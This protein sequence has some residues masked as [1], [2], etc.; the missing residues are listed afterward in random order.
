MG[1]RLFSVRALGNGEHELRLANGHTAVTLSG[2]LEDAHSLLPELRETVAHVGKGTLYAVAHRRMLGAQMN[3]DGGVRTYLLFPGP[4]NWALP[5]DPPLARRT[6][7][8]A[9]GGV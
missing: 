6:R 5:R 4:E 1:P 7:E 3:R 9:A 8:N 2:V